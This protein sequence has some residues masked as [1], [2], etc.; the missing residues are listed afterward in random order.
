MKSGA[1][2]RKALL[3]LLLVLSI[4]A[5]GIAGFVDESDS[6]RVYGAL[7]QAYYLATGDVI[8][9]RPGL[10]INIMNVT[11]P[12]DRKPVVTFRISDG[13]DQGLDKDGVFSPGP[14]TLR[15]IIAYIP[16]NATQY[17]DYTTRPQKSPIT[18]VTANQAG[19][20]SGGK[21]ASLG[22]GTYT[23]TYNT[24]IPSNYD[25][26]ATHTA[27]I[28][29][30]RNLREFGL[31]ELYVDNV[32]KNFVPAGGPVVKIREVVKTANCNA[33][34]DPL[35][36]HGETGRQDVEICILC[37][38]PQ[39][40]DPDTGNTVDMKVMAHKIHMGSSLPSVQAGTPY[41]IIGNSQSVNDYSKVA[42]P[43]DIRN[44]TTCHKNSAQ[45]NNWL[46][47]PTRDTCG[48]C[49]DNIN[50]ETGANH[51]GG[52]QPDDKECA[53]CHQPQGEFEY[54]ASI[55]GA[56]TVPYKSTQ[57]RNPKYEILSITNTG[58]GQKPTVTFR[59]T[60]KT[61]AFIPPSAMS[62][63]YILLGGPTSDYRWTLRETVT[64]APYDASG[65][66]TYTF[67][68]AL[69]ADAAGTYAA[70]M[71]GRIDVTLNPG[72]E[73]AEVYRDAGNNIVVPFT[74]TG[75]TATPRRTVVDIAN[76]N[77]CHDKLQ[78]HGNNRNQ[79][80]AC[81]MCHNPAATVSE[82]TGP[83][84]TIDF[85]IMIHKLHTGEELT[86]EYLSF[87]E[88]LYPGDRRDCLR[89]HV[90]STY[91]VPLPST[92]TPSTTPRDFWSPMLPT[93]AACLGCHDSVEAAAHAYVNTANFSIGPVE[94]CEVC[95]KESAE[96]AVSK[97]HAH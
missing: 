30:T 11:I 43:Q 35:S 5:V 82:A 79:V 2:A 37:H 52:S 10:N 85:K 87:N 17:V 74:V 1:N 34:H 95:H 78:A 9:V 61:G 44:C 77:K 12:A 76:C 56:H 81:V 54:D 80:I 31:E 13:L 63:L 65:V 4:T 46:L 22:D 60:D 16:K 84:E 73:K 58:P 45:V 28:Y 26:T 3:L 8:Y 27:G 40:M 57:L 92:A 91:T 96:F 47:N 24:I 86:R 38:T 42:L 67:K 36:A 39:S 55:S 21:Y 62:R 70:E 6:Q 14:V 7:E 66:A 64:G 19:T 90:G 50:W 15:F 29:G 33:C 53:S 89:C 25:T 41:V 68:G 51:A 71:E 75:T 83:A 97:E 88:V 23:Y 72:T 59:V 32:T 69:P 93:A 49:H 20:D 18:G 48:S 94:S